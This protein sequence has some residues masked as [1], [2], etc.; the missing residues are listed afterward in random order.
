[1]YS[2]NIRTSTMR[3]VALMCAKFVCMTATPIAGPTYPIAIDWLKDTVG[4]PVNRDNQLVA[5]AMMVAARI[6]LPVEA[7]EAV[8]NAT[9]TPAQAAQHLQH[10]QNGRDWG[11]AAQIARRAAAQTMLQTAID[12]ATR[13]RQTNPGGGVLLIADGEDEASE[14][15]AQL[16]ARSVVASRRTPGSESASGTAVVVTTKNDVTGYNF[17]RMGAIITGVYA[18]SAAKRHQLRGRIRRIGQTR[19][20]VWYVTVFTQHSILEL[21][22]QRHNAVDKA[23][24]SMEELAELFVRQAQ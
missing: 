11:A 20:E 22:H 9:F 10:L 4:F 15:L 13:D 3:Q 1:M 12:Y 6:E 17:V 16:S 8:V 23:N 2:V 18:T 14:Y 24:E 19:G 7:K 21:L 5:S